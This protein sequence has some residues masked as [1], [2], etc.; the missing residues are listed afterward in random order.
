MSCRE[1]KSPVHEPTSTLRDSDSSSSHLVSRIQYRQ[2]LS[3]SGTNR[4]RAA[5]RIQHLESSIQHR[6]SKESLSP[7]TFAS[8]YAHDDPAR[9]PPARLS[10]L[11]PIRQ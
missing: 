10:V 8:R 3:S 9:V 1:W 5:S 4:F 7:S 11:F 2:L 6:L